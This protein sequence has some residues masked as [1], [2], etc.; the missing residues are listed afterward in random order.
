MTWYPRFRIEED[1]RPELTRQLR[2]PGARRDH[3]DVGSVLG[4]SRP[5][6]VRTVSRKIL[7]L[8]VDDLATIGDKGFGKTGH[9]PSRMQNA[10]IVVEEQTAHESR[11][12]PRF[13]LP[14]LVRRHHIETAPGMLHHFHFEFGPFE[15]GFT[16]IH[17]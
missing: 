3:G 7:R 13:K 16:R 9:Q 1:A 15:P 4:T 6:T 14:D 11:R 17:F 10:G 5:D 8:A 12:Q 2:C